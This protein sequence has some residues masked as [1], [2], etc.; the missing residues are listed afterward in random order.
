MR[1][2]DLVGGVRRQ[3]ERADLAGPDQ[4]AEHP[5]G[6]LDVHRPVRPVDLVEVEVVGAEPPQARLDGPGQV[7]PRVPA[8]VE[9]LLEREVPLAG[10][11]HLV[12]SVLE[13]LS[14]DHLRLARGV[15]VRGVDQVDPV[16]ESHLHDAGALV[17]VGVAGRAEH[18]RPQGVGRDGHSSA[19][20]GSVL[21]RPSHPTDDRFA[22]RFAQIFLPDELESRHEGRRARRRAASRRRASARGAGP[23][24]PVRLMDALA[25]HGPSTTSTLATTLGLATGSVS[26]HLK[27]LAE[28]GLVAPARRRPPTGA[29]AAGSSSAEAC[30]GRQA[31]SA[32]TP[33][34]RRRRRRHRGCCW[35]GTSSGPV[36]SSRRRP[37][38]GTRRGPPPMCGFEPPRRAGRTGG[39]DGGVAPLRRRR[40]IPDDGAT[41]Q[42]VRAVAMAFPSEP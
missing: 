39:A 19:S 28:A 9:A 38:R 41:R 31:G 10:E 34:A 7:Q 8:A 1:L 13:R 4:V 36:S 16:V 21:H 35:P 2:D 32:T 17:V 23:P 3:P 22:S 14:D 26:H 30:A 33:R 42:T 27:V 37:S 25:V 12:T 24:G 11:D 15:H 29:S 40:E 5:Q 18:H 6:L 20:E